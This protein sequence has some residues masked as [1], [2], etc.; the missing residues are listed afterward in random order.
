M[1][2]EILGG[3]AAYLI[4]IALVLWAGRGWDKVRVHMAGPDETGRDR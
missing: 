4:L 3:V 2:T 1:I